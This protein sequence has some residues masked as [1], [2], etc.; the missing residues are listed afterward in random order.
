MCWAFLSWP[1]WRALRTNGRL[2]RDDRHIERVEEFFR[3]PY[4]WMR[5]E[6]AARIPGYRGGWP[7]WCW[8]RPKP[9]L[10]QEAITTPMGAPCV[11][12]E[13]RLP[14]NRLLCSDFGVWHFPLNRSPVCFTEAED[15]WWDAHPAHYDLMDDTLR[16]QV[17][18]TWPRIFDLDAILR[19]PSYHDGDA[20]RQDV[21][22][23]VEELSMEDVVRVVPYLGLRWPPRCLR[24]QER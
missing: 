1:E 20:S 11:R 8:V 13:L 22:A 16:A 15:A 4:A 23:V 5:G 17:R 3:E 21:Q 7:I 24:R 10:W 9:S 12:L 6:M 19:S 18:A 2:H 14:S